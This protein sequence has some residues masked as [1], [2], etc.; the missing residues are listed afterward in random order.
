MS[1]FKSHVV[2]AKNFKDFIQQGQTA[3]LQRSYSVYGQHRRAEVSNMYYWLNANMSVKSFVPFGVSVDRDRMHGDVVY[4][5]INELENFGIKF[6]SAAN[7]NLFLLVF[8]EWF[9]PA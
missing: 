4:W 3:N 7:R 5:H 9:E 6:S 2:R 1:L 8:G